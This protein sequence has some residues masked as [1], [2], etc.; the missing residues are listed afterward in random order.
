MC[1]KER[2]SERGVLQGRKRKQEQM[3]DLHD[4]PQKIV[5]KIT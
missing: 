4:D 5:S 2:E 3:A 1:N